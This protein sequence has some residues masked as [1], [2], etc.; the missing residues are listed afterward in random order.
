MRAYRNRRKWAVCLLDHRE[1]RRRLTGFADRA[2]TEEL[3]R[4]AEKLIAA[5][6]NNEPPDPA[7]QGWLDS[8]QPRIRDK[9]V[10]WDILD[11]RRVAATRPLTDHLDDF[12]RSLR[13]K[14]RS[15]QH[16]R[17][18]MTRLHTLVKA[19]GFRYFSD[20]SVIDA[21]NYLFK[22]REGGLSVQTNNHYVR[23]V[24]QFCNWMVA[25]RRAT[26][27]PLSQLEALNAKTDRRHERRALSVAELRWF[28]SHVRNSPERRGKTWRMSGE[29]R[30]ML[31]RVAV[32]TGLRS[33]ELR[34][35]TRRSFK[36]EA[37]PAF[38]V[39]KPQDS[40]RRK[41]DILPLRRETVKALQPLL[42]K[43]SSTES[44]FN[45]PRKET[46]AGLILRPDLEGARGAWIQ[47]AED[48]EAEQKKRAESDFLKY[49]DEEG[50]YADFHALRHSF[51]TLIGQNG[52]HLKT[53]Q[54]L[55]R[56]STPTLTAR[57]THGFREDQ[58]RAI[59]ALPHLGEDDSRPQTDDG[60]A[61]DDDHDIAVDDIGEQGDGS[62]GGT[63]GG[64]GGSQQRPSVP[65][66]AH[67]E[68]DK[69]RGT[70]DANVK[71]GGAIREQEGEI[72]WRRHP[73][74]NRGMT[75][76]QT[77]ALPLGY[78]ACPI[79]GKG[80]YIKAAGA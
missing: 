48:D 26:E 56:H 8:M 30:A 42:T 43:I 12:E 16:V 38:V 64:F 54:D 50:R 68:N 58:L 27:S 62:I 28:L 9:L 23:A 61:R 60:Q 74:S 2:Q 13:A 44:V 29:E 46:V 15:E 40:K 21:E 57:Y 53:A 73:D 76:L 79:E 17:D 70:G 7:L 1:R 35:L 18:L 75:V 78:A 69:E 4:K 71:S 41:E 39:V 36:I 34:S 65:L 37:D 80:L 67:Y 63:L 45:M 51:V 72:K 66:G 14:S 47:A 19:C 59:A 3:G 25:K 49:R 31:Y 11:P 24:K 22:R 20:L 33:S 10:E 6:A 77:V 52:V 55:A 5:R 32:E